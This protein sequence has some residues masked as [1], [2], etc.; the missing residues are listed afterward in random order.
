MPK[1]INYSFPT[2]QAAY[3][4]RSEQTRLGRTVSTPYFEAAWNRWTVTIFLYG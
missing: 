2:E 3:Q 4:W 1:A